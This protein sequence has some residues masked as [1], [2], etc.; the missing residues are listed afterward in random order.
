MGAV[1]DAVGNEIDICVEIHRQMNPAESI[2]LGRRLEQFHP[3]FYEDPM[4]PDSP[5]I[6][7]DFRSSATFPLPLASALLLSSSINSYSPPREQPMYD[8]MSA[9]AVD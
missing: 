2:W 3:Y 1:R 4:L 8:R 6:M 9:S 7:A 5:A